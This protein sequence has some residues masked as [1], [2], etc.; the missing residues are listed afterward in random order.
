[1][2]LE[3]TVSVAADVLTPGVVCAPCRAGAHFFD[4]PEGWSDVDSMDLGCPCCLMG[5]EARESTEEER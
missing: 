3:R 5:H 4:W 2:H 1:M